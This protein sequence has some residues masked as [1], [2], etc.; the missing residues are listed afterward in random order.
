MTDHED[1][2]LVALLQD[3]YNQCENRSQTTHTGFLDAHEVGVAEQ[4]C[5]DH[6]IRH[7][8]DGGY[9]DAERCVC[10]FLTEWDGDDEPAP[11]S[12][13]RVTA[14]KG[15][16]PLT[17]RDYLGSILA[18]G[19]DRSLIG[20]IL[21]GPADG[22]HPQETDLV[23]LSDMADY[24]AREYASVGRETVTNQILPISELNTAEIHVET[25]SDTVASLRLD[26]II[27]TAFHLSRGSAQEAIKRGLVYLN[28]REATKA[29]KQVNQ[30][31]KVTLRGK[32]KAVLAE[33]GNKSKK[34]RT[35]IRIERYL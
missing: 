35:F 10:L 34:D 19:I 8:M 9:N 1:E 2:A 15:A 28:S 20:D 17:H 6:R 3:K 29:D 16:R 12:V 33:I 14:K 27:G 18:L 7:R 32:G 13:L 11:L 24:L 30:G 23:V 5:R 4:F 25:I 31:D 22:E 21:V 26:S